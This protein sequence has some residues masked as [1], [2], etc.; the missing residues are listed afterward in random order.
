[1][2]SERASIRVAWTGHR[3][4]LFR[5]PQV[6]RSTLLSTARELLQQ[7]PTERFLVG[8][9]RGVD[10][11]AAEAA[12]LLGVPFSIFLPLAVPAFTHDWSSDDRDMLE[13]TM[14]WA[15]DVEIVDGYSERNRLLATSA[16]V[17]VAVW[18][19][20]AGGG[21]A[22]TVAFAREAGTP[23]REIILAASAAAGSARGRGI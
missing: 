2:T 6:A 15:A 7:V 23:V 18:T 1:L 16:D 4:D 21:T 3:P 5:E 13:Q 22:E 14:H 11:W 8:G 12:H 20:R 19:R 10:T 17:L 9:Q